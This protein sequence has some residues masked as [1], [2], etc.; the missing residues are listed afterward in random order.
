MNKDRIF[1]IVC[2]DLA[3][4]LTKWK[5]A[6]FIGVETG[7]IKLIK[8]NK[9]IVLACGDFD[10]TNNHELQLIKKH[11]KIIEMLSPEKDVLDSEYAIQKAI[12]LQATQ[13]KLVASG[14]R[15]GMIYGL[16]NLL[17]KYQE[18]HLEIF[19]DNNILMLINKPQ[20]VLLA[21]DYKEY[22]YFD[23][24]PL[25]TTK[26]RITGFKYPLNETTTLSQY[27]NYFISNEIIASNAKINLITGY[28]ILTISKANKKIQQI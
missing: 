14:N 17:L 12:A 26:I 3:V 5:A 24:L 22:R 9:D 15:W 11:V 2:Q 16:I 4:D 27:S 6:S 8:E 13:I 18:Y 21:N 23:F 10:H 19:D 1:V 20:T 28:G 7:T 25:V